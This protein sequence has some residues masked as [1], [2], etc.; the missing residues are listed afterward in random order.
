MLTDHLPR[1]PL[2]HLPTPLE[3]MP[4]LTRALGGPR[5]LIKRD[6]QTG[7]A[8][9]GNKTRKLEYLVADDEILV[10][11]IAH[12]QPLPVVDGNVRRVLARLLAL[13]GPEYRRDGPYYNRAEELLDRAVA[14]SERGR[15]DH[16][17]LELLYAT[18]IR[19]A[20]CC[21]LDCAA[22]NRFGL[23][24]NRCFE[25]SSAAI[26]SGA[27]LVRSRSIITTSV[28]IVNTPNESV[29]PS[30]STSRWTCSR[31]SWSLSASARCLPISHRSDE[32][33][34]WKPSRTTAG[35]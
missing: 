9:G 10:L 15:R 4:R 2:G 35:A 19:V 20:E 13:R 32:A 21:G 23:I 8:T 33:M 14:P 31:S 27:T 6:D 24:V 17:L 12:G 11:S 18:G 3:E 22:Q 7:L 28:R 5:L 30:A 29:S 16:A 1:I 34:R 26:V 25:Y